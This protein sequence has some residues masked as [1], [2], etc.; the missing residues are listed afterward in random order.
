MNHTLAIKVH[1][2][3]RIRERLNRIPISR[4]IDKLR[5]AL[6][7]DNADCFLRREYPESIVGICRY[8][9][10]YTSAVYDKEHG[11]IK[12]VGVPLT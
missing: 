5:Q 3:A 8:Q 1:C 4:D 9:N 11:M 7:T 12:T 10:I 2:A 6:L